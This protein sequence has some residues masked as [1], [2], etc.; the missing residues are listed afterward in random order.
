MNSVS[1]SIGAILADAPRKPRLLWANVYC[2]L[3]TSSGA[4]MAVRE[5]LRQLVAHGYLVEVVGAMVFDHERGTTRLQSQCAAVRGSK[6]GVIN[7][8]DGPLRHQ[9]V[10]TASTQ[11]E[12]MTSKEEGTWFHLY[13]TVLDEFRPDVVF[14]YGG[15]VLDR[16]IPAEAKARGIPTAAYL[17][18]SSYAGKS[19]CRDVDLLLTNSQASAEMYARTQGY[20]S[21]ILGAFI[22]PADVVAAQHTREHVLYIN[23]SIEK[24]V[25][26][27][28]QLALLLETRRP[29][30]VFEVVESRGN[31]QAVLGQVSQAMGSPRQ[32]LSNVVITPNTTDMRPVYG[33]ARLLL[34]PTLCW[35]S[36][37]RVLAEAMLNGIPAIVSNRGGMPE[38]IQDGGMK[39]QLPAT[40]YEAPY[41]ALPVLELLEPLVATIIRLHD[42]AHLYAHYVVRAYRVGQTLHGL[43]ISTR[44]LMEALQPLVEMRAGG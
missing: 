35:E 24:G 32:T 1:P 6:G 22:D 4:S 19:W 37:G 38:M 28:I 10:V 25:G 31:W 17:A 21:V 34:A 8:Q 44:G 26:I 5:M 16:L 41:T 27:L 42:D 43:D 12:Q 9:L 40:C 39:L 3:D 33:R 18:N 23:P 11:R 36:S 14:Y 13:Q 2:L 30:I 7:I 15:Q 20:Q 29:D